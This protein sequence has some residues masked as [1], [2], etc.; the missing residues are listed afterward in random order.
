[1]LCRIFIVGYEM[2]GLTLDTFTQAGI[3]VAAFNTRGTGKSGGHNGI[4]LSGRR[5]MV[6]SAQTE[7]EDYESVID[8]VMSYAIERSLPINNLYICVTPP[9]PPI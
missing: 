4:L 8:R 3:L 6:G 9:H 7:V 2:S 5:L 1:M